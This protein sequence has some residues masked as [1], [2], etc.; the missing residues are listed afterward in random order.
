[1]RT[2]NFDKYSDKQKIDVLIIS[3][4]NA[5]RARAWQNFKTK[6]DLIGTACQYGGTYGIKRK[7]FDL[8]KDKTIS[9]LIDIFE[10][11]KS[12]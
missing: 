3:L 5:F 6:T 10:Q 2:R 1:M 7:D 4:S 9:E 11:D 12:L 8:I